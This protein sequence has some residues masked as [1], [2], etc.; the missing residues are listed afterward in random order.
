[1]LIHR[2]LEHCRRRRYVPWSR[3]LTERFGVVDPAGI[4]AEHILP[5]P[6]V[7]AFLVSEQVIE[8]CSLVWAKE[9]EAPACSWILSVD[10]AE[11]VVESD[12]ASGVQLSLNL[13]PG[14][15]VPAQLRRLILDGGNGSYAWSANFTIG[16]R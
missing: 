6:G 3:A 8:L 16:S 9:I 13:R 12:S 1:M 11:I 10:D 4:E 7:D 2:Y 14:C 5:A 15:R